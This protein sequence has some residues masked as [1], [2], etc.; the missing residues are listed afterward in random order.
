M[1]PCY[2]SD[3]LQILQWSGEGKGKGRGGREGGD[4]FAAVLKRGFIFNDAYISFPNK[5]LVEEPP[6]L[7]SVLS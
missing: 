2:R 3:A 6:F 4:D 1:G 5:Q 7:S